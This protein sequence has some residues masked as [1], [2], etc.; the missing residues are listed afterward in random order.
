M[1]FSPFALQDS[2]ALP[3]RW[4]VLSLVPHALMLRKGDRSIDL[5]VPKGRGYFPTGPDD[6]FRSTDLP[7]KAGDEVNVPGL[8]ARV[9]EGGESGP[10]RVH[11]DFD[12]KLESLLWIADGQ[13]GWR[14]V[15]PPQIGFG[16]PLDP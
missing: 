4:W 14:D 5:I 3:E 16:M 7:L 10:G 9:I 6:L 2:G 11:F 13:N 15:P 12:Q 1:L 8:H